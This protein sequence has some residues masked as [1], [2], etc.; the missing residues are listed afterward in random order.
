MNGFYNSAKSG[1]PPRSKIVIPFRMNGFYN[2]S[3]SR[4][5]STAWI[6]IPFRMN[7]FYNIHDGYAKTMNFIVIPF[8][9]NGF[10]N[11]FNPCV[12]RSPYRKRQIVSTY[13]IRYIFCTLSLRGT[14]FSQM[15]VILSVKRATFMLLRIYNILY[16]SSMYSPLPFETDSRVLWCGRLL[17]KRLLKYS[18]FDVQKYNFF[19]K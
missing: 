15:G 7:G 11:T 5:G 17:R 3:V 4:P 6:V 2:P 12:L 16:L 10:Y 14:F 19:R 8:R 9:M 13:C 18:L 1:Q